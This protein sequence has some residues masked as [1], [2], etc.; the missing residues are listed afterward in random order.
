M[1]NLSRELL[2]CVFKIEA[3]KN[4]KG[5]IF[6]IWTFKNNKGNLKHYIACD[7]LQYSYEFNKYTKRGLIRGYET[8]ADCLKVLKSKNII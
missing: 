7:Y 2:E 5:N 3:T 4:F 8:V 6:R 1:K